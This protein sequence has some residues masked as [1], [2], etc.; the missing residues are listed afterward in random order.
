MAK[1]AWTIIIQGKFE[2]QAVDINE[3]LERDIMEQ[4]SNKTK[5]LKKRITRMQADGY[6]IS[7]YQWILKKLET[8]KT[9]YL[10]ALLSTYN[11]E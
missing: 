1:I 5:Y 11:L 3:M 7:R 10:E 4:A 2:K 9:M 6:R 8:K